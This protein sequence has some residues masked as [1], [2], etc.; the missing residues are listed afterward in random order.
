MSPQQVICLRIFDLARIFYAWCPSWR[1][2]LPIYL[3]LGLALGTA[4]PTVQLSRLSKARKLTLNNAKLICFGFFVLVNIQ[5]KN[6]LPKFQAFPVTMGLGMRNTWDKPNKITRF[7]ISCCCTASKN[8]IYFH[9]KLQN[10]SRLTKLDQVLV[11]GP[12]MEAADVQVCFAQLFPST[13]TAVAATVGVGTGGCHLVTGGHI[14]LL[15]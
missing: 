9:I 13:T 10:Y 8:N 1:R 5:K 6:Y 15:Q 2:T 7:Y 12:W 11:S 14:S 3:G 4:L